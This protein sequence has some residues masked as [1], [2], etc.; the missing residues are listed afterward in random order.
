MVDILRDYQDKQGVARFDLAVDWGW[1]WFLTRPFFWLLDT[2]YKY[3]G[4][5]G[6]AILVL[7]VIVKL[8]FFPIANTQFKS[9]SKMKKVQPEM[10]R[11]KEAHG[12][13]P[14]KQQAIA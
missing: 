9:M 6:L 11:L 1:F 7:T 13:D 2:L 14:Q 5:F 12:D 3:L 8:A 4:N 10:V